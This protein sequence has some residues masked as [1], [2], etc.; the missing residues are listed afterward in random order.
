M[1][2]TFSAAPAAFG[3]LHLAALGLIVLIFAFLFPIGRAARG[4]CSRP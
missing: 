1:G 3:G 2:V 4:R